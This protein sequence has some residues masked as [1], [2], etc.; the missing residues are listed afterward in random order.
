[1]KKEHFNFLK[2]NQACEDGLVWAKTQS[3]LYNL[4][5]NCHRGDW[6]LWLANKLKV[7]KRKQVLCAALC[8]HTV[9]H[10]MT[11]ARSRE[12]VRIAFLYGRGKATDEQLREAREAARAATYT[13]TKAAANA[14]AK[15]DNDATTN[16][17]IRAA[18]VATWIATD[19]AANAAV[20]ATGATTWVAADDAVNAA[21]SDAYWAYWTDDTIN[22]ADNDATWAA[23]AEAATD[24]RQANQLRT[25]SIVRKI[26]TEDVLEKI[27][28]IK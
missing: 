28:Y 8:A 26:L 23:A 15:A 24:A 6:L 10:L 5:N 3:D 9:V 1:M 21:A 27:K 19:A 20:R 13:V 18:G 4:W 17:A 11:D 22:D 25:A 2:I 14:T 7:D 12:A 16:N